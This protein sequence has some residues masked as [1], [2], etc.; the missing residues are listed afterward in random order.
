MKIDAY[1]EYLRS[2]NMDD[3]MSGKQI[4]MLLKFEHDHKI[5]L[6]DYVP[7]SDES[8]LIERLNKLQSKEEEWC[9]PLQFAMNRYMNF[10]INRNKSKRLQTI[11]EALGCFD[12]DWLKRSLMK[13]DSKDVEIMGQRRKIHYYDKYGDKRI[14]INSKENVN[15][16]DESFI[17]VCELEKFIDCFPYVFPVTIQDLEEI[18]FN[19]PKIGTLKPS[20]LIPEFNAE[21]LF[22]CYAIIHL[23]QYATI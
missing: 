15:P 11:R 14:Y 1:R 16:I 22:N 7:I 18:Y 9:E 2:I 3:S 10:F 17:S 21:Y 23:L 6:D 19:T 5:D 20:V 12:Y 4:Q 8:D 13:I